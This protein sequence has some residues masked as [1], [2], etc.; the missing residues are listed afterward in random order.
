MKRTIARLLVM[1]WWV[2]LAHELGAAV[3]GPYAS[4]AP[5]RNVRA[6]AELLGAAW[7]FAW[8]FHELSPTGE[9][10]D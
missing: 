7:V 2:L 5:V 4:P 8:A 6:G 9:P 3:R 10:E 1:V